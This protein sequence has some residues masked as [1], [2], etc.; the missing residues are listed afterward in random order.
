MP[1]FFQDTLFGIICRGLSRGRLFA[2]QDD[3]DEDLRR[4][5]NEASQDKSDSA[6]E[7]EKG[8]PQNYILIDYREH[9]PDHPRN[10]SLAKKC[11]VTFQISL[12]TFSI[13]IGSAIYSSGLEDITQ[14]FGVS[15][16]VAILGLTLYVIGYGL[17]PMVWAPLSEIPMI[18]RS[19]VYILTL[20]V[21][22]FFNFG[23]VYAKNIG[24]VSSVPLRCERMLTRHSSWRSDSSLACSDLRSWPLAAPPSLTCFAR[25]SAHTQCQSMV[26]PTSAAPRSDQ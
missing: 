22:V 4:R 14:H 24:M 26:W 7:L 16:T 6:D 25:P 18:G 8:K 2:Y 10:W 15:Q 13:Y 3:Q 19:P 23:V 11:F 9:D 1:G 5:Y 21:F 12:L 17:G 20:V